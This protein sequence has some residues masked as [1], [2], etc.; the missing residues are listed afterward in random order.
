MAL[1]RTAVVVGVGPGHFYNM[2]ILL[3]RGISSSLKLLEAPLKPLFRN[4]IT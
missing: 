1:Q 3:T 2:Q 4:I